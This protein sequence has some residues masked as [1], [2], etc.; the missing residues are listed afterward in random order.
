MLIREVSWGSILGSILLNVFIKDLEE[1]LAVDDTKLEGAVKILESKTAMHRDLG[2]LEK[3]A[4]RNL[5][6]DKSEVLWLGGSNPLQWHK[7][8][9]DGLAG[10]FAE[11]DL[12]SW[13][14][15]V[16]PRRAEP[17]QHVLCSQERSRQFHGCPLC[18]SKEFRIPDISV[19]QTGFNLLDLLR[20]R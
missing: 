5:K 8:S 14:T 3:R 17:S 11:R 2:K 18:H 9:T 12:P 20:S 6:K 10:S 1:D 16:R 15:A 7:L 4:N 13:W 19:K